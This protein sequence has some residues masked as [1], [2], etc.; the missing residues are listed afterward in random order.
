MN[1]ILIGM[2]YITQDLIDC[3]YLK[4]EKYIYNVFTTTFYI[5]AYLRYCVTPSNYG[6]YPR[7]H[8]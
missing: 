5:Q 3:Q 6:L 1:A 4:F 2:L 7:I 8:R